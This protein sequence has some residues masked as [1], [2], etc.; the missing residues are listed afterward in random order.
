MIKVDRRREGRV[1]REI[2]WR[3]K[4]REGY[5]E[6]YRERS[7]WIV[8]VREREEYREAERERRRIQ[9][10]RRREK[11]KYKKCKTYG[12]KSTYTK[13]RLWM[14]DWEREKTKEFEKE[15]DI[16]VKEKIKRERLKV[17]ER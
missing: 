14:H 5:V 9:R 13:R 1:Q 12:K 15:K 4:R 6:E 7:R 2:Q 10:E 16:L 17:R 11:R 8:R 3:R